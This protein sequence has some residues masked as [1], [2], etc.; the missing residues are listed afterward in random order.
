[1]AEIVIQ[2]QTHEGGIT[3]IIGG[4]AH[5]GFT[6]CGIAAL[7]LMGRLQDID[8]SR[9]LL[10]MSQRQVSFGGFNG[11]TN[12]LI[13]SCYS[14]WIGATYNILNDYFEEK[15]SIDDHLLYSQQDLQKYIQLYC[16][17]LPSGGLWDKPGKSRDIYHTCYALSGLSASQEY[18]IVL[19]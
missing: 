8:I 15:V 5:G 18:D 9:L 17:D 2:S 7:A 3:N 16:Q 10:W 19:N 14:F 4:E 11:R 12:K 1:M 13:D 6:F